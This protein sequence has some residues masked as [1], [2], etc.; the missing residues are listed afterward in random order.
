MLASRTG[1]DIC[2]CQ[3]IGKYC[4][5]KQF[6]GIFFDVTRTSTGNM[7][8]SQI[9]N[10]SNVVTNWATAFRRL[11]VD[12]TCALGTDRDCSHNKSRQNESNQQCW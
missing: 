12:A 6:E 3:K 10:K 5:K 8:T 1:N 4:Q 11:I 2:G 7:G 9:V